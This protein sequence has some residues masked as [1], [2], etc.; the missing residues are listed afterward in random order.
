[1]R[2]LLPIAFSMAVSLKYSTQ[3]CLTKRNGV[4]SL[5]LTKDIQGLVGS[6]VEKRL[7][8]LA[9]NSNVSGK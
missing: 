9:K 1:M 3:T 8:S 4:L 2:T 6:N 5:H 7:T